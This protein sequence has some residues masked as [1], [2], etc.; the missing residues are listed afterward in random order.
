VR[1]C[2]KVVNSEGKVVD[3]NEQQRNSINEV[4]NGFASDALRTLCIA[5][6]D[7]EGSSDDGNGIP[8]DKY[9]LI[10]IIGIKDPVRPGVKEAVKTCLDAGITVRMVT[11]DNINT[12]KAIARECGILTD[13][14]AIEGPDFRNKTQREMEEIIPKLQVVF[15]FHSAYTL[16]NF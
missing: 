8:E 6:K 15:L 9:T 1:M 5:F 11:G 16:F 10:A 12:A 7:I 14:L 3:L 13:G 2:D 4:I